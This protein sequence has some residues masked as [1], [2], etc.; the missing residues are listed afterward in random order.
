[1]RRS[2]EMNCEIYDCK[3]EAIAHCSR[4]GL[5]ACASHLEGKEFFYCNLWR[6]ECE[7]IEKEET[8][9]M[10]HRFWHDLCWFLKL[11]LKICDQFDW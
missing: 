11:Y 5:N 8:R 4:C 10:I 6:E 2:E 1:M 3:E 7:N 9:E